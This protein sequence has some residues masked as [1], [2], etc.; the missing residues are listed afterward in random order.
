MHHTAENAVSVC[1]MFSWFNKKI[2][3]IVIIISSLFTKLVEIAL[4]KNGK[5][6]ISVFES[7]CH[8]LTTHGG[9][10]TLFLF[11]GKR[12]ARKLQISIFLIF[13]SALLGIE[14]KS[15]VSVADALSTQPLI[16]IV[17][18]IADGYVG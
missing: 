4:D 10:F 17:A 15:A 3:L 11:I 2:K 16:S 6:T 14:P 18:N 5:G 12:Q 7:S 8:Q 9:G 13:G 1:H